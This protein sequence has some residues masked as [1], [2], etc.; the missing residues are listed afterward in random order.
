MNESNFI[1]LT[2]KV[3]SDKTTI[4][5]TSP[6]SDTVTT[7]ESGTRPHPDMMVEIAKLDAILNSVFKNNIM[8]ATGMTIKK[9]EK[10]EQISVTGKATFSSGRTSGLSSES[11]TQSGYYDFEDTL[12]ETKELIRLEAF[13]YVFDGKKA[14]TQADIP[15]AKSG[16]DTVSQ[17]QKNQD[18]KEE[19]DK[20]SAEEVPDAPI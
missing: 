13:A 16:E 1:L 18:I 4:K 7:K 15:A 14:D 3:T 2:A 11:F 6:G 12:W 9:G 10:E 5:F 17:E 19:A 8:T 20:N